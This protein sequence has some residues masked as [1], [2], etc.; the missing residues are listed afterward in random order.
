MQQVRPTF[1]RQSNNFPKEAEGESYWEVGTALRS[2][3]T[4]YEIKEKQRC[5]AHEE[6]HQAL[7]CERTSVGA[8]KKEGT[9]VNDERFDIYHLWSR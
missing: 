6:V 1:L 3:G 2:S 5:I 4:C 7:S 8:A 9:F